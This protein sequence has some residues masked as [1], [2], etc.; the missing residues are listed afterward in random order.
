VDKT[1]TLTDNGTYTID[2]EAYA[3]GTPAI[4][5]IIDG[6]P[7]DVV[8]V[9]DQS[10][11][12][13]SGDGGGSLETLKSSVTS[14]I[15]ALKTN[16]EAFGVNHRVSI[17]GFAS[18]AKQGASGV[19][20][21]GLSYANDIQDNAWI[22]TGLFVNGQFKDYGTLEYIPVESVDDIVSDRYNLGYWL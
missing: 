11:S 9:L 21:Y 2:L 22:N 8:L 18:A 12:L 14:F 7:L 1:A 4:T 16:G 13:F 5:S 15:E 10:G 3:T 6:I 19:K 20:H 17:C